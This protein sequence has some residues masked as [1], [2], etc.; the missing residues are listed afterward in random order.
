M[1]GVDSDHLQK[2]IA[3]TFNWCH[4]IIYIWF[5]LFLKVL[6]FEILVLVMIHFQK[7]K[8]QINSIIH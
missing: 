6:N 3:R 4:L 8:K 7:K 5:W 2:K 1:F